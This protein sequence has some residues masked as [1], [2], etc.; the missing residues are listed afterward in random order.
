MGAGKKTA[1]NLTSMSNTR[2]LNS[3]RDSLSLP[4][5]AAVAKAIHSSAA[6]CDTKSKQFW[7]SALACSMI[8]PVSWKM[9]VQIL[10]LLRAV[11]EGNLVN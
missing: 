4:L 10:R 7:P 8:L 1:K 2:M 9:L 6:L 3:S 5:A 11:R